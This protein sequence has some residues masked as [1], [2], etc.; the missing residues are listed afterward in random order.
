MMPAG[1]MNRRT[2]AISMMMTMPMISSTTS[3][4]IPVRSGM[5]KG[6]GIIAKKSPLFVSQ[7]SIYVFP[8]E[9]NNSRRVRTVT[10]GFIPEPKYNA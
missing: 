8:D 2:L 1:K 4:S 9:E 3:N 5:S 6:R 7:N 10:A